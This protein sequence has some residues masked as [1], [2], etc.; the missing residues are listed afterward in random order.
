MSRQVGAVSERFLGSTRREPAVGLWSKRPWGCRAGGGIGPGRPGGSEGIGNRGRD[1]RRSAILDRPPS[2]GA[3]LVEDAAVGAGLGDEDD[4][5]QD[6]LA[7]GTAERIDFVRAT[8]ELGPSTAKGGRGGGDRGRRR[9]RRRG[10]ARLRRERRTPLSLAASLQLS[11]HDVG[12]GAAVANEVPSRIGNVR[13]ESGDESAGVECFG[14]LAIVAVAGKVGGG[15][16]PRIPAQEGEAHWVA[17]AVA[18]EG[19]ESAAVTGWNGDRVVRAEAGVVP[20]EEEAGA[21][22]GDGS[23]RARRASRRRRG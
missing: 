20:G 23:P 4:H 7:A 17:Q 1:E 10:N 18:G 8:N 19:L 3:K 6:A 21:T 15:L 16:R 5:A 22:A 9:R 14:S 2:R 12:V 11:A 13:E